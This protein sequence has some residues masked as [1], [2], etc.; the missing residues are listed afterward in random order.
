MSFTTKKGSRESLRKLQAMPG[1]GRK[2]FTLGP[3][4]RFIAVLASL[5][6]TSLEES[7]SV[8]S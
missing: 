2:S 4:T 7:S 6:E 1:E 5:L 8:G 3:Y